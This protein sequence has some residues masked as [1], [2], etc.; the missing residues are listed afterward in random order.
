MF[1]KQETF[2]GINVSISHVLVPFLKIKNDLFWNIPILRSGVMQ[3]VFRSECRSCEIG[4]QIFFNVM[5]LF[6]N[7]DEPAM[8]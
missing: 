5:F 4:S 7:L 1:Y 3:M 2:A 8:T 6:S